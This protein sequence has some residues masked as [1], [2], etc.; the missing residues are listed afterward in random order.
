[1]RVDVT[2]GAQFSFHPPAHGQNY[3]AKKTKSKSDVS[4]EHP[5]RS[6]PAYGRQ[7]LAGPWQ[8]QLGFV[9]LDGS[10]EPRVVLH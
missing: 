4:T 3:E 6:A 8:S 2:S 5:D 9:P 10:F 7:R 1:V